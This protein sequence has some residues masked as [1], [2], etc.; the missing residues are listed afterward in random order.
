MRQAGICRNHLV[1]TRAEKCCM[2][3][4]SCR[5]IWMSM[6]GR[7]PPKAGLGS[8]GGGLR[9]SFDN[10][11]APFVDHYQKLIR[12]FKCLSIHRVRAS[13]WAPSPFPSFDTNNSLVVVCAPP[14]S[15]SFAENGGVV[16]EMCMSNPIYCLG[17]VSLVVHRLCQC[18]R[19][20]LH[21][22]C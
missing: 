1:D 10:L 22:R 7:M 2:H 11:R 17:I 16:G 6:C 15:M 3:G 12:M 18:A 9:G 14:A 5:L 20:A 13:D 8:G 4:C 21:V 19:A